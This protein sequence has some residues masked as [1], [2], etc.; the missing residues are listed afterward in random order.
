[1]QRDKKK[2]KQTSAESHNLLSIDVEDWFH[3]CGVGDYLPRQSWDGLESRVVPNT[4]KLLELLD[5]YKANATFFI[6]GWVARRQPDLVREIAR[7]GHEVASHGWDHKRVHTQSPETFRRDVGRSLEILTPLAGRPVRGYRAPQWSISQTNAWALEILIQAGF[8]YDASMAPLLFIGHQSAPRHI[9][10]VQ[11]PQGIIWEVPPLVGVTPWINLPVGGGWGLRTFPYTL[12]RYFIRRQSHDHG[13]ALIFL[14]PREMD[15]DPPQV[16]L[17]LVKRF[18][19]TA[20]LQST[21]KRLEQLLRDYRFTGIWNHL[22]NFEKKKIES[23]D[24]TNYLRW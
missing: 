13:P 4:L 10:A 6:L 1:V 12:I 5:R 18:V 14:H 15:P 17:P 7:R 9:H 20:G 22:Q 11:T 2:Y 24:M 16:R 23:V 21:T 3:I 8:S 19:V